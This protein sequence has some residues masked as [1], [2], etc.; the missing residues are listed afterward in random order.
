MLV[1]SSAVVLRHIRLSHSVVGPGFGVGSARSGRRLAAAQADRDGQVGVDRGDRRHR[2]RVQ[3]AAV[4]QQAAVEHVRGDHAGDRDRRPDRRVDR[5]ALQP[6][7]LAGDQVGA[8]P[9]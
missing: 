5:T 4:G 6:H 8:T 7:R 9:R 1:S 2:Q 3:D